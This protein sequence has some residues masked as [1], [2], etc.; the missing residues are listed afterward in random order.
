MILGRKVQ[1]EQTRIIFCGDRD[2]ENTQ[3][4][5]NVIQDNVQRYGDFLMI[6]GC[7]RGADSI[8]LHLAEVVFRLP[9]LKIPA[10]V[11]GFGKHAWFVRNKTM[12]A[13]GRP[14]VVVVFHNYL[15]Y[16]KGTK[17]MFDIA[18]LANIPRVWYTEYVKELDERISL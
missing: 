5:R 3:I 9:V 4:I 13:E 6:N 7:S 10:N 1:Q 18:G 8:A 11:D 17:H 14:H 12:L 16:S 2:W 15:Q